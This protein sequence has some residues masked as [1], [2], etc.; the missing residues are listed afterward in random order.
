MDLVFG[1]FWQE[2]DRCQRGFKGLHYCLNSIMRTK[3]RMGNGG[4]A[5]VWWKI[6]HHK[7]G[8]FFFPYSKIRTYCQES[9]FANHEPTGYSAERRIDTGFAGIKGL[10]ECL[11]AAKFL[12]LCIE[13]RERVAE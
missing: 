6:F 12:D 2:K 7:S 8:Y 3:R 13:L 10:L 4:Y 9:L 11:K 5:G 1:E